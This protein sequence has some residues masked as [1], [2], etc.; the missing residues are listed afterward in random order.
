MKGRF[1]MGVF[2]STK[3]FPIV[4]SDMKSLV[5]DVTNHFAA[6]EFE[7]KDQP[8]VSGGWHISLSKGGVFKSI[9]GM[10]SS[11]NI[12]II[13]SIE[14]TIA[15]AEVGIFGQQAIPS[16]I[17]LFVTWPVLLT[18]I[19]GMIKQSQLDDEVMDC[20]EKNIAKYEKSKETTFNIDD[21]VYCVECGTKINKGIEICPKCGGKRQH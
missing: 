4:V 6:L 8:L 15:K 12:E 20:I 10:K 18:Q 9:L 11:L 3:K 14:G 19:W 13:N 21:T 7:V 1:S 5:N 16:I 2:S 17:S